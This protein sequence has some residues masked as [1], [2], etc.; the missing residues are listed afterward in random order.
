M[1]PGHG[2]KQ[3]L[4]LIEDWP[5]KSP[6]GQ[7]VCV[8]AMIGIIRQENIPGTYI[9]FVLFNQIPDRKFGTQELNR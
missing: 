2:K 5:E 8:P 7:M 6:V 3:E 1:G 9:V 4:A